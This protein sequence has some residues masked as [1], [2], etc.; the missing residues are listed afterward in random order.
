M[1]RSINPGARYRVKG[2]VD[3]FLLGLRESFDA[4]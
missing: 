2:G 3:N 1:V 4:L